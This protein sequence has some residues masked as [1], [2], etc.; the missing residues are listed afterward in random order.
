MENID[1]EEKHS[2]EQAKDQDSCLW[3]QSEP[4]ENKKKNK[5]KRISVPYIKE[6]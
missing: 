1:A 6:L 2:G 3:Y 5:L 4:F